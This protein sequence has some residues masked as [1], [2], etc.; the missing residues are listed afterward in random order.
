[1]HSNKQRCHIRLSALIVNVL[2][3]YVYIKMYNSFIKK[4]KFDVI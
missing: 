1:M 3:I 4:T 2:D